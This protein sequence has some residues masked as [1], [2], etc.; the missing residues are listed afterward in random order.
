VPAFKVVT[1]NLLNDRTRWPER[2]SILAAQMA[3]LQPDLI[4]LQEA[5][6]RPDNNAH[7]L[8]DQLGGYQ[9]VYCPKTGRK[10]DREGIAILS[11]WPIERES[12][13]E[14]GTQERV[15]QSIQVQLHARSLILA[16]THLY[17][18]PGESTERNDQVGRLLDWLS[19]HP[20]EAALVVCGDFNGTP[21]STAIKLMRGRF[22][23]AYAARHGHEPE[24]TCPTPL[25]VQ[26]PQTRRDYR[27]ALRRL[28]IKLLTDRTLKP[29]RGTLDY[30]FVHQPLRVVEC[31]VV[32]NRP[33]PDDP[34]LYP[35]DHFGLAATLEM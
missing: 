32:L 9:V 3:E 27:R 34:S 2:R 25:A 22:Q 26:R 5:T 20:A 35:S 30:I 17:W 7:W 18:W 12:K 14:F 10:R 21:D 16:N 15:A 29:W 8:A 23:S 4:A 28:L 31:D 11:R 19:Q 24:Y 13:L 33:A 1:L 6:P